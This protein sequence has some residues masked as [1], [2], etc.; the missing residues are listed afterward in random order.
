MLTS[1][2]ILLILN[3]S[4]VPAHETEFVCTAPRN[5][6]YPHLGSTGH[7]PQ[8]SPGPPL[9]QK[10]K[11]D[12][13]DS[14]SVDSITSVKFLEHVIWERKLARNRLNNI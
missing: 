5:P 14:H 9:H 12:T 7:L 4:A 8:T 3:L 10:K 13:T 6:S 2:K 1:P 11:P